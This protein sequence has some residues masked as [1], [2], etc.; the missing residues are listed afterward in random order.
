MRPLALVYLLA[1]LA[2][3]A[4]GSEMLLFD[5]GRGRMELRLGVGTVDAHLL[6]NASTEREWD[7]TGYR[8]ALVMSF[9]GR[10]G[11]SD[12]RFRGLF[13]ETTEVDSADV[14][15]DGYDLRTRVGY[16]WEPR[17]RTVFSLLGALSYRSWKSHIKTESEETNYDSEV[18]CLGGYAHLRSG[19]LKKRLFLSAEIGAEFPVEGN[20]AYAEVETSRLNGEVI[21]ESRVG[22]EWRFGEYSW[23]TLGLTWEQAELDFGGGPNTVDEITSTMFEVGLSLSF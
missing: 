4:G 8:P 16:G 9:T 19:L 6:Q 14:D 13:S 20:A 17:K 18:I 1:L 15:L 10:G 2:G 22:L 21:M 3:A 12:F 5:E 7:A 11:S 23:L